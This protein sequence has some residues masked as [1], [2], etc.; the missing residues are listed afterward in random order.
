LRDLGWVLVI[1][2]VWFGYRQARGA[3][4]LIPADRATLAGA[5]T[6][7]DT[8]G[9]VLELGDQRG[10]VVVVNLWASWCAPCRREVPRLSRLYRDFGPRGL[11]VW[12]INAE[13]FEGADLQRAVAALGIDYP[14][15]TAVSRLEDALAGG[16]VLPYTWLIDRAGRVR[17]THGGLPAEGSLR[18][19]CRELLD[20][21]APD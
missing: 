9:Q 10:V 1:L 4:R 19:A 7:R 17:A 12:A 14:A 21:P 15:L 8:S 16:D 18:R 3:L 13:F 2:A 20:E 5:L 6:V 11:T